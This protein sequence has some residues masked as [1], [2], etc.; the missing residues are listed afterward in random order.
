M[1]S[2]LIN[3]PIFLEIGKGILDE[4]DNILRKNNVAFTKPVIITGYKSSKVLE[5]FDFFKKFPRFYISSNNVETLYD[6]KSSMYGKGF[7]LIIAA[8]GGRIIDSGKF[9]SL[10]TTLPMISVP[11]ILSSDSVSSPISILKVNGVTRSTGTVMPTGVIIDLDIIK[12]SPKEYLK[13]GLGDLMSNLSASNDWE[14]AFRRGYEKV[15]NFARMLAS[16]PA[17][18]LLSKLD[19]YENER[20]VEFLKDLSEGLVLSGVSMGIAG[21][22]RPASGSEHNIS[23]SLD[24]IL[25]DKKKLHGL[26]VG[27]MTLF[28]LQLQGNSSIVNKLAELYRKMSFPTRPQEISINTETLRK[29]VRISLSI[30]DRYT[31]LNEFDADELAYRVEEFFKNI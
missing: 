16:L 9:L 11:T 12:T 5:K 10:E 24:R 21:S 4:F 25:G 18:R 22:S 26:Q 19:F 28:T 31:I 7:D 1:I 29:A 6:L 13:A 14:L 30:R 23:H 3:I 17:E 20:D 2:R 27:V 8:G 15:D